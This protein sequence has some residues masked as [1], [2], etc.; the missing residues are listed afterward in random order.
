MLHLNNYGSCI[1]LG[2]KTLE[3][4]C[5]TLPVDMIESFFELCGRVRKPLQSSYYAQYN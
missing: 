4:F 3:L 1:V 2:L 5:L